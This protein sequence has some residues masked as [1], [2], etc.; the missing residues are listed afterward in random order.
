MHKNLF[1]IQHR[2]L[3]C[4]D[5]HFLEASAGT[6]KTYAIEH[7]FARL[8]IE[9]SLPIDKILVVT[10][11]RAAAR[12]LKMR[13]RST[14]IRTKEWLLDPNPGLDYLVEIQENG[15]VD[16]AV[17]KIDAALV[18]FDLAQIFTLHGFCHRLLSEFSFECKIAK[19]LAPPEQSLPSFYYNMVVLDYLLQ[20][21]LPRDYSP[22]QLKIL[23]KKAQD[24]PFRLIG[25]IV[26]LLNS[27]IEI[28]SYPSLYELHEKFRAKLHDFPDVEEERLIDDFNRLSA[29]YKGMKNT[30]FQEQ[31]AAIT[32]IVQERICSREAFEKLISDKEWFLDQMRPEHLKIKRA[33]LNEES[34]NYPGIFDKMRKD[35]L[36]WIKEAGSPIKILLR[37]AKDC[38]ARAEQGIIAQECF[39]PD[40]MLR[41]VDA[42][43]DSPAFLEAVRS[44]YKAAII[45][46]FQ[47]TDPI[48]WRIFKRAFLG[49]LE[50]VCL[51][52]D[53]KQSIYAFRSADIYTYLDAAEALGKENHKYLDTNFRSAPAL[54]AALN[55]LFSAPKGKGWIPLPRLQRV[56]PV[57]PVKAGSKAADLS[58]LVSRGAIHFFLAHAERGRSGQWPSRVTE[59]NQLFPFLASEIRDIQ[60]K[61][62]VPFEEMAILVK[63]RFQA[64]RLLVYFEG[65]GIPSA[66]RRGENI[67]HSDALSAFKECLE[68]VLAPSDLSSP[69]KAMGWDIDRMG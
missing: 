33:P 49:H 68:A 30:D 67:S 19:E 17:K 69:Q 23:L 22:E 44:K 43:L 34:L 25:K 58:P 1:D 26:S 66:F 40:Q 64:Q 18:C 35:L 63:D 24:D 45:D 10:F 41:R 11:T 42:A 60:R 55:C 13:I 15:V 2:S 38:Q 48:Q 57:D 51:V 4:Q 3:K 20:G 36:P 5:V 52:G 54:I 37:L 62:N 16:D 47:D 29:N 6:G 59:E 28:A 39:S 8:I 27:E 32:A 7:L 21:I 65:Q 14:L 12:E 46:E 56:M 31:L 61:R 9:A 53:P 50:T